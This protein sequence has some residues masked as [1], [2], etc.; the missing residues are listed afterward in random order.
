MK[1]F[2]SVF[3]NIYLDIYLLF[4]ISCIS[5]LFILLKINILGLKY[6]IPII[7]GLVILCIINGI[8]LLN[9]KLKKKIK[10]FFSVITT[11][12]LI[13]FIVLSVVLINVFSSVKN[14][15]STKS[16]VDYSVMVKK[17]SNYKELDD[18]NNKIIGFYQDDSYHE[19]AEKRL[20]SKIE[21]EYIGYSSLE[22]LENALLGEEIDALMILDS[23]LDIIHNDEIEEV[24]EEKTDTKEDDFK[25]K[26]RVI[27]TF[28][29]TI[30]NSKKEKDID[31]ENGS[32]VVFVSGQDSYA[33]SVSESSRSDVNLLMAVNL[34]TK[35]ILLVSIPRDYYINI[36][37]KNAYDKL[38]HI[39]IYGSETATQSLGDIMDVD[40]L[41]YVKFN[42]TTFMRAIEYILPLDVY[43]DFDFTTGVYDQTIGNSYT[44]S[45]GYNHITSGEM[46]LQFVRARKN[47]SEGDRQRGI[48]QSR[49][50]RAVINKA[51]TPQV[52]LKYNDILK[53]LDGTFLTNISDDS[54]MEIVKYVINHNGKFKIS[55]YSVNGY[56]SM[57]ACYSSGSQLLYAMIPDDD[58]VNQASL[59]IKDVLEGRVP[60]IETDASELADSSITHSVSKT[61]Y[62]ETY[63]PTPSVIVPKVEETDKDKDKDKEKES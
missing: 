15:F 53:S 8:I 61:P 31:L 29:L 9:K 36:H 10:I 47:F 59:Y 25:D 26:T 34:K 51:T 30:D 39:S 58:S 55:S 2:F 16:Y 11:L 50:L 18:I 62:K 44:F 35:Q 14:I 3:K 5:L 52:L 60:D 37:G 12:L 40:V 23:Y 38:T 43:S 24:E 46:A 54:I 22:E 19:R 45:Q 32:F 7:I 41:Y 21:A 20:S 17:E 4:I 49:M 27:Y 63:Y 6:L 48:N 33:S 42:F 56:D 28:K 1:K 57:K 13:G